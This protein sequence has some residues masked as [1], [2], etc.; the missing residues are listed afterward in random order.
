[1]LGKVTGRGTLEIW[2]NSVPWDEKMI[3]NGSSDI[4]CAPTLSILGRRRLSEI[5]RAARVEQTR[6]TKSL[7]RQFLSRRVKKTLEQT[8]EK[9][10]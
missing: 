6:R 8:L 2:A 10:C 3:E 5:R 9:K 4:N 1:M 7:S